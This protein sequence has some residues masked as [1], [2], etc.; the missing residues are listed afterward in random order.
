MLTYENA[1]EKYQLAIMLACTGHA[2]Q[3]YGDGFYFE[4]LKAVEKILIDE[5]LC[6]FTKDDGDFTQAYLK[7]YTYKICA[8]FHDL[9]EDSGI[10]SYNDIANTYGFGKEIAEVCFLLKEFPGRNRK[11]RKPPEYYIRIG[12]NIVAGNVKIADRIANIEN[13]TK[14][15]MKDMYIKEQNEFSLIYE[16]NPYAFAKLWTRLEKALK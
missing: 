7:A 15:S 10:V 13:S 9:M 14:P 16:Q 5:G 2:L 12:Q 3:R 1:E 11:E 6:N 8:W 4:H